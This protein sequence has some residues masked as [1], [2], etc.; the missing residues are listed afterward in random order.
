MEST[1]SRFRFQRFRRKWKR[2]K[3]LKTLKF[4]DFHYLPPTGEVFQHLP[5]VGLVQTEEEMRLKKFKQSSAAEAAKARADLSTQLADSMAPSDL[6]ARVAHYRRLLADANDKI[7]SLGL[8]ISEMEE[9]AAKT[10]ADTEYLLSLCVPRSRHEREK[11]AAF[12]L[13]KNKATSLAEPDDVPSNLSEA[14]YGLKPPQ[15]WSR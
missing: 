8:Q 12:N 10:K 6:R 7:A 2:W 11:L 5:H 13:A 9:K 4:P 14:I 3:P 15:K 1:E